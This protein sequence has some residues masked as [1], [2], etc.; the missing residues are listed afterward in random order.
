[1]DQITPRE[2]EREMIS[3]A[4]RINLNSRLITIKLAALGLGGTDEAKVAT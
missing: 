1:M 2:K 3:W 4:S